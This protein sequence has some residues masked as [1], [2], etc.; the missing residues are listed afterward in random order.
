MSEA[1]IDRIFQRLDSISDRL[2]KLEGIIEQHLKSCDERE[3]PQPP[4]NEHTKWMEWLVRA[5]V[6]IIAALVGANVKLLAV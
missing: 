5:L 4:K 6:A 2:S 1:A 3:R